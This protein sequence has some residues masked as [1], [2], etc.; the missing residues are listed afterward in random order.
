MR[1][2]SHSL[3]GLGGGKYGVVHRA[4]AVSQQ[5]PEQRDGE[6]S[7]AGVAGKKEAPVSSVGNEPPHGSADTD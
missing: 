7:I 6:Y 2:V 1:G 5:H 3:G 4:C